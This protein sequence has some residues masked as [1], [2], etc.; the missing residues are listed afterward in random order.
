[1][2]LRVIYKEKEKSSFDVGLV[3]VAW[4]AIMYCSEHA[5]EEPE[6]FLQDTF[7]EAESARGAKGTYRLFIVSLCNGPTNVQSVVGAEGTYRLRG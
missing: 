4:E 1:M 5:I 6:R 7:W 3:G 2:R